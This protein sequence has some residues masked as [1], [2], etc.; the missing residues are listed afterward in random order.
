MVHFAFS[1]FLVPVSAP[2]DMANCAGVPA[3]RA[4]RVYSVFVRTVGG[5][6]GGAG[7]YF[8]RGFFQAEGVEPAIQAGIEQP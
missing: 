3:V 4:K 5:I 7:P 1:F 2:H 8:Q 6:G